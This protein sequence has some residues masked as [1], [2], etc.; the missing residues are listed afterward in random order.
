MSTSI[1]FD[2]RPHAFQVAAV[3]LRFQ[4]AWLRSVPARDG[5]LRF[6]WLTGIS[7]HVD[8]RGGVGRSQMFAV[9]AD[10]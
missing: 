2:I 5:I 8:G 1:R 10:A 3:R 6:D 7:V 9:S 4:L